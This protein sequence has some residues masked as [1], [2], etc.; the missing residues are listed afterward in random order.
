MGDSEGPWVSHGV[1]GTY[2]MVS[3]P[4]KGRYGAPG[5]LEVSSASLSLGSLSHGDGFLVLMH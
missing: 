2:K 4:D 5:A 3:L 1:L